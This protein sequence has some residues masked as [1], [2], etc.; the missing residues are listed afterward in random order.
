MPLIALR[1]CTM[2]VTRARDLVLHRDTSRLRDAT[3]HL[4]PAS[5]LVSLLYGLSASL[6]AYKA[7][8]SLA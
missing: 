2:G 6:I 1:C 5:V 8:P 7:Q 3:P 4:D